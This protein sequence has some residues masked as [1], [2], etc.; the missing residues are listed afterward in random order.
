MSFFLAN[1]K[2]AHRVML[3][4]LVALAGLAM[5]AAIFLGQRQVEAQ[6]RAA[7]EALA[8]S[9][10][11]V[12]RVNAAIRDSL[13]WE[14]DFLLNK[15]EEDVG[16]FEQARAE[17]QRLLD[18][19][20][21]GADPQVGGLISAVQAALGHYTQAFETLVKA[22]RALGLT[23][24]SGLEGA[25]RSAVHSIE[26]QLQSVDDSEM[27]ASM[28]MLRRHE[29]DFILRRDAAY[30][31]K[32]AAEVQNFTVL[33]KK[34]FRPGAQ[35]QRV[36][37]ALDVYGS[38]FRLYSASTLEE[39]AAR[40]SVSDAYA[41]ITPVIGEV[42]S[43]YAEAKDANLRENQHVAQRNLIIVSGLLAATVVILLT[44]VFVIG[45]SIAGPV[46]S[47]SSAMHRL[48]TG[49]TAL[50]I[51]GLG[52]KNEIGEMAKAL[53]IFRQA[54]IA[55]HALEDEAREARLAAE[56]DRLRMQ[57]EAEAAARD[58]LSHATAAL[59]NA[60]NRLAGGDLSFAIAEPFAPDFESLRHDLNQTLRQLGTVMGDIA[61]STASIDG[62]SRK[63]SGGAGDLAQ[64]TE[65]QAAS[66][67]ETA[68]ALDEMTAN[69]TQASR[70][71]Q[72]ARDVASRAR[73]S[74]TKTS[75]LVEEAI[76]AMGRIE[77]SAGTIT[78]IIGVIDEIA[79]QTNLLALNAG[80][81]AARA[82]EAGR[83]FAVVAHEVRALAQ[84]SATAA[85]EIKQLIERSNAGVE[86]GARHVRDTSTA[87]R[88]I[89]DFVHVMDSHMDAIAVATR[90]QA[91]G[92]AQINAAINILDQG[93]QQ[94]AGLVQENNV[95]SS[96]LAD[97][98]DRLRELVSQ[99]RLAAATSGRPASH[100]GDRLAARKVA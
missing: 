94:N 20:K 81:E 71:A 73:T 51:P 26:K 43:A 95:S 84:R 15:K 17:A 97:E 87:L 5:I 27:R 96:V 55:K 61:N 68:A 72:E 77:E 38:A 70:R 67:E 98:A 89:G 13:L 6:Y 86:E 50:K 42:L 22:N 24:S 45:R 39:A 88:E 57:E 78:S 90:E 18:E 85:Q 11:N 10:A 25:M 91:T 66:L 53:D 59:A 56:A 76:N 93:T 33:A 19:L 31:E 80:I 37:E 29:K 7:A 62:T 3:L 65:Q 63:I 21:A 44:S 32:H 100:E 48:A 60:L 54:A 14:Q 49:E 9:E 52:R 64:R 99:F 47:M 83:G 58:R 74:A 35:R 36:M 12:G 79:F 75:T 40:T 41:A 2:I 23:P 92:L 1:L 28:L 4:G 16:Q 46:V 8:S 69:V 82:G 34:L 30:I